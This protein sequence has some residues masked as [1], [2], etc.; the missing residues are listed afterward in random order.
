MILLSASLSSPNGIPKWGWHTTTAG[1]AE[2]PE[3]K[4]PEELQGAD[5]QQGQETNRKCDRE[6]P[7]RTGTVQGKTKVEGLFLFFSFV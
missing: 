1:T 6:G 2:A 3:L 5:Q 7:V 4:E